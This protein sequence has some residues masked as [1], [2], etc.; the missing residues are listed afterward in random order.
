MVG[1][2]STLAT[3]ITEDPDMLG[4]MRG[5]VLSVGM[6]LVGWTVVHAERVLT[7]IG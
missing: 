4:C 1:S 3:S 7:A 5:R 6:I 2:R